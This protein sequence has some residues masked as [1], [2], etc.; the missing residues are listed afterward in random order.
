ME[1]AMTTVQERAITTALNVL[2]VGFFECPK[3]YYEYFIH[4]DD[5]A[6]LMTAAGVNAIGTPPQQVA[7][8]V[9]GNAV[10]REGFFDS[11]TDFRPPRHFCSFL[12][13]QIRRGQRVMKLDACAEGQRTCPYATFEGLKGSAAPV[14]LGGGKGARHGG[15]HAERHAA[16]GPPVPDKPLA[17]GGGTETT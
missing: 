5:W 10:A 6:L 13:D 9:L 11:M 16:T 15:K 17:Q 8:R 1:A 7:V 3:H 12:Q 2:S 4:E 14:V